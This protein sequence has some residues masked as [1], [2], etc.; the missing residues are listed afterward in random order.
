MPL[1][2]VYALLFADTG[3]SDAKISVLFMLWSTTAI[4]AEVPSGALADRFSRRAALIASS[5][6]QAVGFLLWIVLPG[7]V[8]FA[9][10]FILWGA[11]VAATST[12]FVRASGK[13]PPRRW[14][15]LRWS[16]QR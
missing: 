12:C 1:Y 3:L 14:S 6:F 15:V 5:L 13:R 9:A 7:F 11:A 4:V 16:R 10:G 8:S 2:A